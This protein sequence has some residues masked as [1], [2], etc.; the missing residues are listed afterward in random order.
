VY[1][2]E[3]LKAPNVLGT[4]EALRLS[5]KNKVK[6]FHFVSSTSVLDTPHYINFL[7]VGETVSES[8]NLEGSRTGLGSGYGQSKWVSEKLIMRAQERGVPATIIRP[9]YI[10]GDSLTGVSNS[11]DFLWRLV[12]GCIQLG[13]IP[14][15]SNIINMCPVDY[16][17]N[18][19]AEIVG[20]EKSIPKKVFHIWN[21]QG[22]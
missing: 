8:D 4:I 12:K 9:G 18:S 21:S 15:I 22:Y 1:P 20:T 5:V 6:P 10:V 17:S 13:K 14:R 16:V 11:D 19:I 3:K 2:Y 7:N